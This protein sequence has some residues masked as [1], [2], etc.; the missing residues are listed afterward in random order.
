MLLPEGRALSLSRLC[1]HSPPEMPFGTRFEE[2]RLTSSL[3]NLIKSA[4]SSFA[5][6]IQLRQLIHKT[7]ANSERMR[8]GK[9]NLRKS[10]ADLVETA[11]SRGN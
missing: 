11:G 2:L 6:D 3:A 7:L 8:R 1:K 5:L 4:L 9:R 10:R